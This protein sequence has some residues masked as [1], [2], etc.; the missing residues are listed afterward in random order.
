[1]LDLYKKTFLGMQVVIFLITVGMF[2]VLQRDWVPCVKFFAT[3]QVA[4]IMGAVWG[5]RLKAR[6]RASAM[7]GGI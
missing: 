1:M 3:M 2:L 7:K 4:S 6:M 5:Q